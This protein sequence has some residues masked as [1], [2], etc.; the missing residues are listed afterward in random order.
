[1]DGDTGISVC[2]ICGPYREMEPPYGETEV[3]HRETE[4]LY[5]NTRCPYRHAK[6]LAC[7]TL[8]LNR[9]PGLL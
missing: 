6:L 9:L 5:G 2:D 1:M 7:E 3:I 8:I 4:R